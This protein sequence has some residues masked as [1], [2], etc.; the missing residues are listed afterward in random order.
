MQQAETHRYISADNSVR[1]YEQAGVSAA[2]IVLGVPFYG[3]VWG[4]VSATNH[5]L[6][7]PGR[8]IPNAFAKYSDISN[9]MLTSGFTRYWDETASAPYLYNPQKQI[10]VSY[11]DP[12]SLAL[13]SKYLLYHHLGGIM[14]WNYTA[15][16]SGTLLDAIDK[17]LGEPAA[18][19]A[20]K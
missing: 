11:E 14:F 1:E 9:T 13:K 19:K 10:F 7:Q 18:Q 3:H 17:G 8:P 4:H 2:K 15:D 6:F 16:P 20:A 12:Q 5:G